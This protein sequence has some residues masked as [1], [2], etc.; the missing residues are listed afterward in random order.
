LHINA[1]KGRLEGD[2]DTILLYGIVKMLEYDDTG[3]PTL[4]VSTTHVEVSLE[5][6]YA[7]T[8]RHATIVTNSAVITG[9]GMRA[10]LPKGR[11]EVIK[12]EKTTINAASGS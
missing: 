11:L 9:T 5:D 1:E 4:E 2:D 8:E 10:Y 7:Q 3:S 6:E 12:H